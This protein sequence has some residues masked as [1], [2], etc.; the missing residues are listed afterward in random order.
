MWE[1]ISKVFKARDL[2]NKI[3]FVLAML[4]IFRIA[5]KITIPGIDHDS[6]KDLLSGNQFLGFL[7]LFS[8]GALDNLSIVM[9]GIAPYITS[10]NHDLP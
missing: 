1:S 9:L 8:G 5:A 6:L 2:R 10:F 3:F 4:V 7:N